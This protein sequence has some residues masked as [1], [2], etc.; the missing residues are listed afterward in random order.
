M[1]EAA[2]RNECVMIM[3]G[4]INCP[5]FSPAYYGNHLSPCQPIS[6]WRRADGLSR[7]ILQSQLTVQYL[8]ILCQFPFISLCFT[9][10]ILSSLY[11]S[12]IALLCNVWRVVLYGVVCWLR[13]CSDD[14]SLVLIPVRPQLKTAKPGHAMNVEDN[15][16]YYSLLQLFRGYKMWKPDIKTKCANESASG[17]LPMVNQ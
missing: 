15:E 14:L 6:H 11:N 17:I 13:H 10:A 7:S 9:L 2:T 4:S 5:P 12:H 8:W 16:V 3:N 1:R